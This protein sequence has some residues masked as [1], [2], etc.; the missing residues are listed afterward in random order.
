[1]SPR[2]AVNRDRGERRQEMG[3]RRGQRV[4]A[5]GLSSLA[6][7]GRKRFSE[8]EKSLAGSDSVAEKKINV[9]STREEV[10]SPQGLSAYSNERKRL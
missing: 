5:R 2:Q 6:G 7:W 10:P 9:G 3:E 4:V 8:E 1:V